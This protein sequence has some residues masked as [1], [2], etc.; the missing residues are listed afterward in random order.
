MK[1]S[2]LGDL[3]AFKFTVFENDLPISKQCIYYKI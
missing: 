2:N 3:S 1:V